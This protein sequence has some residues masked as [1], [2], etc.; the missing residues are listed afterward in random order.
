MSP[1]FCTM[2]ELARAVPDAGQHLNDCFLYILNKQK[3][4]P[5]PDATGRMQQVL[6]LL[7][8]QCRRFSRRWMV[9][10]LTPSRRASSE[11]LL[12]HSPSWR[13]NASLSTCPP[14]GRA[15]V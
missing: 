10:R 15:S 3:I 14:P 5:A 4:A 6:H 2:E 7:Q 9:E 8:G 1:P 12:P 13:R 11:T